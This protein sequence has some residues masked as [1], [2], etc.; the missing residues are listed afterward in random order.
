L[1]CN[2]VTTS[3]PAGYTLDNIVSVAATSSLDALDTSYSYYGAT[4]VDIAA[5]GTLIYSCGIASD[6][7]YVYMS[8][9]S[10]ATP[11]V[12]GVVALMKAQFPTESPAQLR[13]RLIATA[14]L[15]PS[16]TGKCVS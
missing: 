14:D 16:L 12:S 11:V 6:S 15:L 13:Q 8:G 4:S 10:M 2:D 3:Y 7:S 5:P 1:M 9:T